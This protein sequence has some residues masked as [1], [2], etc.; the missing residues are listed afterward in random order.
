MDLPYID[1]FPSTSQ[2]GYDRLLPNISHIFSLNFSKATTKAYA[3][4]ITTLH[5]ITFYLTHV[6]LH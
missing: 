4:S 3:F 1:Q 2:L 5:T 6:L